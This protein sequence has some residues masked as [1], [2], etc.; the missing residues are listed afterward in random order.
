MERWTK[1]RDK[2]GTGS[3]TDEN[4]FA[5]D[6]VLMPFL[7]NVVCIEASTVGIEKMKQEFLIQDGFDYVIKSRIPNGVFVCKSKK[8]EIRVTI[9]PNGSLKYV[10][11]FSEE[12][13]HEESSVFLRISGNKEIGAHCFMY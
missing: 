3:I 11:L 1:Y 5:D 10:T 9:M 8:M 4:G 6:K 2:P 13:G 7:N 12:S